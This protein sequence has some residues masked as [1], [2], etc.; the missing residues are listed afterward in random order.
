MLSFSSEINTYFKRKNK[1]E[2][3]CFEYGQWNFRSKVFLENDT[4]KLRYVVN[5]KLYLPIQCS[6]PNIT[7]LQFRVLSIHKTYF[8]LRHNGLIKFLL[9]ARIF[10]AQTLLLS[11]RFMNHK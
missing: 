8:V 2:W 6:Y 7:E 11:L 9:Y 10:R 1:R 5:S 4:V 3:D